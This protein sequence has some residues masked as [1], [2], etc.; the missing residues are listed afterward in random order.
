MNQRSQP[1]DI[2][3]EGWLL[4][5]QLVNKLLKYGNKILYW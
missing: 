2:I 3:S 4:L 1:F 5:L